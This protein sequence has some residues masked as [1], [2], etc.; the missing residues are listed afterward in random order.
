M[1]SENP[2]AIAFSAKS[3][4]MLLMWLIGGSFISRPLPLRAFFACG[5]SGQE[6]SPSPSST[7]EAA[8]DTSALEAQ[9]GQRRRVF[10]ILREMSLLLI[11]LA[12]LLLLDLAVAAGLAVAP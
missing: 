5:S 1:T 9:R 7:R 3:A 4:K 11:E 8:D 2:A 6:S 10:S 12:V